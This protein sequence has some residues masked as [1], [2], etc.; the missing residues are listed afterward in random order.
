MD[1][2]FGVL[3]KWVALCFIAGLLSGCGN[4]SKKPTSSS[5]PLGEINTLE[6]SSVIAVTTTV[7]GM[8]INRTEKQTLK[9]DYSA[10][11]LFQNITPMNESSGVRSNVGMLAIGNI[12]THETRECIH[13]V[14]PQ[15]PSIPCICTQTPQEFVDPFDSGKGFILV[16]TEKCP[17]LQAN[18]TKWTKKVYPR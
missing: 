16:S 2:A 13:E 1:S 15:I 10:L 5:W 7:G 14:F 4:P 12:I 6:M 3:L 18:C 11:K 8:S 9:A 17:G